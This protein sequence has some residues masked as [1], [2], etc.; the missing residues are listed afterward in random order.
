MELSHV[1]D[2]VFSLFRGAPVTFPAVS[3]VDAY[4][5]G[6]RDGRLM[7][8][9]SEVDPRGL[10]TALRYAFIAEYIGRGIGRIR[11]AGMHLNDLLGMEVR[12]MPLTAFFAPEA[13]ERFETVLEEVV[14]RPRVADLTLRAERGIGRPGFQARMYLA[15]LG[16]DWTE[17]PRVLGC[18][19]SHGSIGRT[20][21]RF[22]IE[23]AQMRRLVASA[24]AG[25]TPSPAPKQRQRPVVPGFAEP[26]VAFKRFAPS[27]QETTGVARP[28]LRLVK[29]GD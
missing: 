17:T 4:W 8:D 20:P 1:R 3:Q 24:P 15:P 29:G 14:T 22:V 2:N 25:T 12:G 5:E 21:R 28:A 18:L 26:S 10:E 7:P 11:V 23:A 13:R 9:R 16:A 6:L 19:E 27:E